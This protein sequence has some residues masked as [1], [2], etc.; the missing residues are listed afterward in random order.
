MPAMI[1]SI[2]K[3]RTDTRSLKTEQQFR[4]N[5]FEWK[6]LQPWS[7]ILKHLAVPKSRSPFAWKNLQAS[8]L[9]PRI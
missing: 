3:K 1:G 5:P 9:F 2:R 4:P 8:S 7:L 6:N